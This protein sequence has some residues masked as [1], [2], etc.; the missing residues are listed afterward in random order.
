VKRD[1]GW[2]VLWTL[3]PFGWG[4]W[5]GYMEAAE[6][7]GVERYTRLSHAYGAGFVALVVI[8]VLA[9]ELVS[10][11][12]GG[13]LILSGW[14]FGIVHGLWERAHY[15]NI[16]NEEDPDERHVRDRRQALKLAASDPELAREMRIGLP[17]G[18]GGLVDV[19]A[20]DVR[21]LKRLPGI[22][23]AT[24]RRIVAL[25]DELGP[26]SSL[27]ELGMTADL[28]GDIVEALRGRVVF[29]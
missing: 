14:A 4:I 23:K 5:F 21:R 11:P 13:W 18:A 3:F 7:S 19:N 6:R 2:W 9:I 22:S 25:R 29:L 28:P 1:R 24:A 15:L 10:E 12:A 8:A 20:A 16:V 26:Y 27:A 17:G